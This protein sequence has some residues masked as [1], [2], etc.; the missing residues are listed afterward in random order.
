[1]RKRRRQE[2]ERNRA[3]RAMM[4]AHTPGLYQHPE[5]SSTN[6]HW[7]AEIQ[8]G[9]I[10]S[11]TRKKMADNSKTARASSTRS[12][13]ASSI[14]IDASTSMERSDSALS[15]LGPYRRNDDVLSG[16]R[17]SDISGRP[18]LG[19]ASSSRDALPA[20][21]PR[22][23]LRDTHRNRSY[24][25]SQNPAVNDMHPPTT[26]KVQSK[27]EVMWMLQPPP[28]PEAMSGKAWSQSSRDDSIIS[29]PSVS[30]RGKV[31]SRP[32]SQ[33]TAPR[34][35]VTS[36]TGANVRQSAKYLEVPVRLTR[37][38]TL[39]AGI[40]PATRKTPP[41]LQLSPDRADGMKVSSRPHLSTI[42]SE[43]PS[44]RVD[45]FENHAPPRSDSL[46][47]THNER[48][49]SRER[50]P[51]ATKDATRAPFMETLLLVPSQDFADEHG[52]ES[53]EG[54]ECWTR[55]D[56]ELP[57]WIHDHTAREVRQRWSFEL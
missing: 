1:M 41:S 53:S 17:A 27:E 25:H 23:A 22:A 14:S 8:A 29:R 9:P 33:G 55:P 52:Q 2:A 57:Q 12:N 13:I 47:D 50:S 15:G 44:P 36:S 19:T 24:V 39:P 34:S 6:P 11:R 7:Q 16:S 18:R 43:G 51:T 45:D 46:D 10:P 31:A 38:R 56:F 21:L 20:R 37:S 48:T 35:P 30:S 54:L 3:Q 42:L 32:A 28:V 5:P 26:R 40:K 4:E 49:L